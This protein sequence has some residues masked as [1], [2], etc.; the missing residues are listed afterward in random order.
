MNRLWALALLPVLLLFAAPA[1]AQPGQNRHMAVS[2][3]AET[4][5]VQPGTTLTLAF[6]M[7]PQ[8]GWHG[9]WRNP[10]DSGEPRDPGEPGHPRGA[11]GGQIP[12][13]AA[14][15]RSATSMIWARC[16]CGLSISS[17]T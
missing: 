2:L 10:G 12:D 5:T 14:S 16:D 8:P 4:A 11:P 13:Q 1:M 9:Y 7:R 17:A 3:A 6:V 15:R